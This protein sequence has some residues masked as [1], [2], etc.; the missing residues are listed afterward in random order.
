[1]SMKAW[2]VEEP[3]EGY[4]TVVF[5]ET[6]GKAKYYGIKCEE[7]LMDCEFFDVRARRVPQLDKYARDGEPYVMNFSN[8]KDRLIMVRDA[9]FRCLEPDYDDCE[10]CIAKD[11][12]DEYQDH[13]ESEKG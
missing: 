10:K 5:A 2:I 8:D 9:G 6:K 11:Y 13:L 1:M 4:G 12:C 3:V 7:Q